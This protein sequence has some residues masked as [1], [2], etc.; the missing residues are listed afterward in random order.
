VIFKYIGRH[1]KVDGNGFGKVSADA[2][3]P[4]RQSKDLNGVELVTIWLA[5]PCQLAK[6]DIDLQEI[7]E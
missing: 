5:K 3:G 6:H 4:L 7:V 1:Q 2:T